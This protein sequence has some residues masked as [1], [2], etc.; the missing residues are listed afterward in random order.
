MVADVTWF[1]RPSEVPESIYL[2]L[3]DD[4]QDGNTIII[5]ITVY[6]ITIL[7]VI[8]Y[9]DIF[10]DKRIRERQLFI[11]LSCLDLRPLEASL[12]RCDGVMAKPMNMCLSLVLHTGESV[13]CFN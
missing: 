7:C 4:Q 5:V 12:F 1:Y 13:R 10:K 9:G 11:S 6:H 3:L 2:H 8:E